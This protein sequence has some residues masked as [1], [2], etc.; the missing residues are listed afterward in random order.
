MITEIIINI[1]ID[2]YQNATIAPVKIAPANAQ[3][4]NSFKQP[5]AT[6]K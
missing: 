4:I 1:G 2:I 5:S 6:S 3:P